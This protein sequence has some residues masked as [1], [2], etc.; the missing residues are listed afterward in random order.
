MRAQDDNSLQSKGIASTRLHELAALSQ[1]RGDLEIGEVL[2][3][4]GQTGT[5][6][7]AGE[8]IET[9]RVNLRTADT[10]WHLFPVSPLPRRAVRG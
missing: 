10:A 9:L 7:R 8:P 4:M 1:L 2:S 5:L 6:G 3:V